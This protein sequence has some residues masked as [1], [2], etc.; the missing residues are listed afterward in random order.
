M[1]WAY[2]ALARIDGRPAGH[3][4]TWIDKS[5]YH[6]YRSSPGVSWRRIRVTDEQAAVMCA[7]ECSLETLLREVSQAANGEG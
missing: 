3:C 2:E 5:H 6:P 7:R 1:A 4:G